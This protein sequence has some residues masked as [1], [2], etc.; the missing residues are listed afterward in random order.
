MPANTQ[1]FPDAVFQ[2]ERASGALSATYTG[3]IR[4]AD[5]AARGVA[6]VLDLTAFV[7]AASLQVAIE[8]FDANS[9]K[10]I[11][12]LAATPVAATGTFMYIVAPGATAAGGGVTKSVSA[13]LTQ[14][15]RIRVIAGN[16]NSHTY[17]VSFA[18]L[19]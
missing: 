3:N 15:W 2:V 7:T 16:G 14:T 1:V 10:F 18:Y 19:G 5:P 11:D 17:S 13:W 9:G 8:V 12:L 6:V 4:T